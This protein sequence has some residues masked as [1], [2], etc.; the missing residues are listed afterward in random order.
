MVLESFPFA[1]NL[2]LKMDFFSLLA[3]MV[4]PYPQIV[5]LKNRTTEK[6]TCINYIVWNMQT[7]TH[8]RCYGLLSLIDKEVD[9]MDDFIVQ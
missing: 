7:I 3:P 5:I 9:K 8:L 4:T 1:A 6:L 2:R